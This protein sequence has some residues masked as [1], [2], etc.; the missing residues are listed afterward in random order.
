[1]TDDNYE[2]EG[3]E[4]AN[5]SVKFIINVCTT[6]VHRKGNVDQTGVL[7]I[8]RSCLTGVKVDVDNLIM[9]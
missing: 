9:Q 2:V 7:N 8:I 1:M 4:S 6:L 3:S 5:G